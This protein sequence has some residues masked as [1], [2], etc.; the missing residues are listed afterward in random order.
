[1]SV[2][3]KKNAIRT[4]RDKET[5]RSWLLEAIGLSSKTWYADEAAIDDTDD[6][7]WKERIERILV[8]F[9]YYGF[10]RIHAQ[11]LRDGHT[12]NKKRV[13][14]IMQAYKLVPVSVLIPVSTSQTTSLRSHLSK[15]H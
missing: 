9:P 8:K 7:E 6:L 5:P 13:Q 2:E 3:E 14:R 10:R 15:H 12:I 11:L 4:H 1:M